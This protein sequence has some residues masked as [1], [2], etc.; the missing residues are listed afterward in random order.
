MKKSLLTKSVMAAGIFGLSIAANTA[1]A[2]F[3]DVKFYAGAG[4]DYNTYR[5]S[6]AAKE[7]FNVSNKANGMGLAV[8][9]IGLKFHENFGLEMGYSFNKK[10]KFEGQSTSGVNQRKDTTNFKVKNMYVDLMGFMPLIDSF[11]LI[12]G[13]GLGRLTTKSDNIDV[14]IGAN[15]GTLP[16]T[17]KNKTSWRVKL[18]TQYNCTANLAF[19]ALATYQNA[20][21]KYQVGAGNI[22]ALAYTAGQEKKLVKNMKSIGLSAIYTF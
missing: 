14:T 10:F 20:G 9:V 16:L 7:Q 17:V 21:S 22:G 11:D 18:G 13:I 2:S 1:T 19:R 3:G 12:G 4:L 5:I 6:Q 8:P 15:K